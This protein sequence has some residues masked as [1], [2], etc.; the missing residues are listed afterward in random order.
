MTMKNL[1]DLYINEIRDIYYAEK[2]LAEE[3]PRMA[4]KSV[5]SWIENSIWNTRRG[6]YDTRRKTWEDILY[7]RTV[8]TR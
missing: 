8:T 3:L 5:F 1:Y 7:A 4:K 6:N 2:I